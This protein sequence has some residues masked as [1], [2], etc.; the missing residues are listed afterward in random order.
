MRRTRGSG[1]PGRGA[2]LILVLHVALNSGGERDVVRND[3]L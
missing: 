2:G 1:D 3:E